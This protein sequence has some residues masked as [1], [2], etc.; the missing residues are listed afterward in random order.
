MEPPHICICCTYYFHYSSLP[1]LLWY[2][3]C[4]I[5]QKNCIWRSSFFYFSY[6]CLI[7]SP[8]LCWSVRQQI[9][10]I[11]DSCF[12][13]MLFFC[14]FKRIDIIMPQIIPATHY[15]RSC[16]F[17]C[18]CCCFDEFPFYAVDSCCHIPECKESYWKMENWAMYQCL[19][20]F[21]RTTDSKFFISTFLTRQLSLKFAWFI[22]TKILSFWTRSWW[23][24]TF[25]SP[26][27][28]KLFFGHTILNFRL[29]YFRSN[30][31]TQHKE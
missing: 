13:F 15:L 21:F 20:S 11:E 16:T 8:F 22:V 5:P 9:I 30:E 10:V 26:L 19:E 2:G 18:Y 14:S 28:F 24:C 29:P 12:L 31:N 7:V 27:H 4:K 17:L 23:N 1:W 6:F 25:S 3:A